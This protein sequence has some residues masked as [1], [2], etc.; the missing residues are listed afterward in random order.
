MTSR[1]TSFI[2]SVSAHAEA[3]VRCNAIVALASLGRSD[4]ID[5]ILQYALTDPGQR[6]RHCATAE[7]LDV[8][9]EEAQRVADMLTQKLRSS[10]DSER[11][12]S[13]ELLGVLRT[14]GR[15]RRAA[16]VPAVVKLRA[17]TATVRAHATFAVVRVCI[18]AA[19]IGALLTWVL[20]RTALGAAAFES[21]ADDVIAIIVTTAI[22]GSILVLAAAALTRPYTSHFFRRL[23]AILE[24]AN[25]LIAPLGLV[26][27]MTMLLAIENERDALVF[28]Q[29]SAGLLLLIALARVGSFAAAANATRPRSAYVAALSIGFSLPMFLILLALTAALAGVARSGLIAAIAAPWSFGWPVALAAAAVFADIE[30]TELRQ[31]LSISPQRHGSRRRRGAVTVLALLLP[32]LLITALTAAMTGL[33]HTRGVVVQAPADHFPVVTRVAEVPFTLTYV[34]PQPRR[35]WVWAYPQESDVDIHIVNAEG[36]ETYDPFSDAHGTYHLRV[37]RRGVADTVDTEHGWL[38]YRVT[39]G[40]LGPRATLPPYV[41]VAVGFTADSIDMMRRGVELLG[42]DAPPRSRADSME[43]ADTL[44]SL[45]YGSIPGHSGEQFVLQRA[46]QLGPSLPIGWT[47]ICFDRAVE[48]Q[49][50]HGSTASICDLAVQFEGAQARSARGILYARLGQLSEAA[51][52]FEAYVGWAA[53][54]PQHQAAVARRRAWLLEL[55]AGRDPFTAEQLAE[56]RDP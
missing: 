32:L 19:I 35:V 21:D 45:L 9:P 37:S 7:L 15:V 2:E 3:P 27:F 53:D 10:D 52:D 1:T 25:C 17:M 16:T 36:E 20:H 46:H 41:V 5:A 14:S 13:Y 40:L 43:L 39:Q 4:A 49:L 47:S 50:Q 48:A 12:R 30:R 8:P 38:A 54:N 18:A 55:R 29:Y 24:V 42:G 11:R 33:H 31:H 44:L 51:Q 6:V 22:G 26:L 34:V 28:L 23:A 56:L